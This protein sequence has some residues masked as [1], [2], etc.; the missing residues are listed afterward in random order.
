MPTLLHVDA[1]FRTE[2]S[3]SRAIADSAASAWLA[4]NPSG[5]LVHR[6]LSAA[7]IPADAWALSI[8]T[9]YAPQEDWS[10]EQRA[11]KDLAT[12]LADE[13]INA[14]VLLVASPLFNFGISQYTKVWIDMLITDPRL[15]P[16]STA[17]EGKPALLVIAQGGGYRAGA[18]RHGWD[19]ATAYLERIFRDNFG[20]TVNTVI[21]DLTLATTTPAMAH[22]VDAAEQ[23]LSDAHESAARHV[24]RVNTVGQGLA[25]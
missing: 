20:M 18:P 24:T 16:G 10:P 6:D 19:H 8:G 3:T 7:P 2:G 21:A 17:L 11:A 23:A 22:L 4:E 5:T 14:D 1:S 15:G 9:A 25:A 12:T 13:V